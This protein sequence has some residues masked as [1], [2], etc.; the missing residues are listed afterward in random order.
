MK[1]LE[2]E[3]KK[4]LRTYA[5][6]IP[7]AQLLKNDDEK[8]V[9]S[10]IKLPAVVKSQVPIGGR[11]KLG[12]VGIATTA[13]DLH[14]IVTRLFS[15]DIS[16]FIPQTLLI[17]EVIAI[18]KEFY[19]A[20]LINRSKSC[21]EL[22]A[23]R[24]G[25]V[26]IESHAGNEFLHYQ[27]SM[28]TL[29]GIGEALAETYDLPEKA[30]ALQDLAEK[31]YECFIKSD[32]TLL[33]INPLILTNQGELV[34]GDCKMVLDDAT[35]F[36]HR[37]WSFEEKP[38]GANFVTLN[39]NGTI[40]TIANGAGLAMATVDAVTT[41]GFVPANFLDIGGS[42]TVESVVAAFRSISLFPQVSA[43]VINIFGGIVRCDEV[44]RAIIEARDALPHL[45]ALYIRLSGT[46]ADM[47][48][49]L[50]HQHGL[51]LYQSLEDCLG[52]LPS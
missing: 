31:L 10:T 24:D 49:D 16:G 39:K 40:A 26:E 36:R 33:E 28:S 17:E 13:A 47:A 14:E 5:V 46:N 50:L 25:G 4:L 9:F 7:V 32:A 48:T 19:I 3:G 51:L 37:E 42:A 41:R 44:A 18:D 6:P 34:A 29:G 38:T 35:E 21:V 20:V 11:E 52:A 43:I 30:F 45:P 15:L 23:H 1:L 8:N 22:V 27:L 2:Y 12:G